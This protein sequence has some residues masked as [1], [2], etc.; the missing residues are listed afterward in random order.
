ML[1]DFTPQLTAVCVIYIIVIMLVLLDLVAGIRKAKRAGLYRSSQGLRRTVDKLIR[2]FNMMLVMTCIDAVQ[3]ITCHMINIQADK[4]IPVI[5]L[6]TVLGCIFIGFIEL[7]S[8][9][10]S[11][12]DKDKAKIEEAAKLLKA[13]LTDEKN[14]DL[15]KKILDYAN[16]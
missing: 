13:L 2:Y 16:K 12:E 1:S 15:V 9:Y 8:V 6:F 3:M 7:K 5:T 4:H 11:N 14:R 10:E